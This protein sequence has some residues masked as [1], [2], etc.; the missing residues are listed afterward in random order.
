[1]SG[2]ITHGGGALIDRAGGSSSIPELTSDPSSPAVQSAWV[3]KSGGGGGTIAAGTP[4]GL[5]LALTY[6]LD[7]SGGGP[8][9]YQ[10]SYRTIENTTIRVSMS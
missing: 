1:M 2:L 4:L 5:L 10:F 9:T 8:A 6:A 3:L 7:S